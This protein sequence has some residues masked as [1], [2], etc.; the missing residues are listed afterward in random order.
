MISFVDLCSGIGGGRLGLENNGFKCIGYSEILKKSVDVYKIFY[1]TEG[2]IELGD[3]TK[4]DVENFPACDLLIA[5]FPCQSYSI[6]GLRKG[7]DDERGQIIFYIKRFLEEKCIKYFILENVKGLVNHNKGKTLNL[8]VKMLENAGYNVYYDVL[9]SND[10]GLPQKRERIYFV[11]IR[12]GLNC[13]NFVF[14]KPF[15][16]K[17]NLK[18][19]LIDDD[20]KYEYNNFEWLYKYMN[21]K[22]N[23]GKYKL[24]DILKEDY[25]I[26]DTRQSDI[27]FFRGYI[28]T[29]RTGRSGI[30]YVKNGKLR[31]LSG[32]ESLLLQGFGKKIYDKAK[33]FNDSMLLQQTGNAM[34]VNV[35]ENIG[36]SLKEIMK[37][38]GDI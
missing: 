22:Y 15:V 23:R 6:Q 14:P 18:D 19:F 11:G 32:R 38:N 27:R 5:G 12:K 21:N 28:P 36:N 20:E 3:L 9:K 25:L 16:N 8:I 33:N 4:I 17:V 2:E 24:E 34:S 37:K 29:L 26:V 31:K 1:N 10:F 35:I 13:T 7:L 30:L